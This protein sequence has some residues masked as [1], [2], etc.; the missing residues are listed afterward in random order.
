[1]AKRARNPDQ[2]VL[3][4]DGM[5]PPRKPPRPPMRRES[6]QINLFAAVRLSIEDSQFVHDFSARELASHGIRGKMRRADLLHVS[7]FR[8]PPMT[9]DE[10]LNRIYKHIDTLQLPA[11]DVRFESI[12]KYANTKGAYVLVGDQD[13]KPVRKL[14]EL[15]FKAIFGEGSSLKGSF[16]PHMTVCY[17][18]AHELKKTAISPVSFR[19]AELVIIR[20][21]VRRSHHEV[22][23]S[24]PLNG[25]G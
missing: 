4:G 14:R 18:P 2:G 10:V 24:W 11:F 5:E 21:H 8:L 6:P 22:L 25:E 12:M 9:S 23:R 15:L 20:S 17:D 19:A 3:F 1:M 13:M 7:L 16:D